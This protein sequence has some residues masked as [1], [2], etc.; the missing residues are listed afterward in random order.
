MNIWVVLGIIGLVVAIG[1][2]F[3]MIKINEELNRWV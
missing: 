2:I 3:V 1:F